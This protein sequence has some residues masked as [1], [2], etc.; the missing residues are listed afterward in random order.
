MRLI[1][2][3]LLFYW[4]C[5]ATALSGGEEQAIKDLLIAFPILGHLRPPWTSNASEAC[6]K[7]PF[8]GI[9]CGDS[10]EIHVTELYD[11]LFE[12]STTITSSLLLT[13]VFSIP[14]H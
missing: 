9:M 13:T 1:A 5:T 6:N 8:K 14:G 4:I 12:I 3:I 11:Q 2:I 10:P 7:P